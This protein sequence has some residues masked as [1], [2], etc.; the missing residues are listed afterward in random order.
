[1][2]DGNGGPVPIGVPGELYVGGA[3]VARGYLGRPDLTARAVRA[4][5]LRRRPGARGSTAT[6]DLARWRPDGDLEF[7][8]RLDHQVKIRGFRIE[9]GEIEARAAAASRRCRR[10]SWWLGRTSTGDR[11]LVAYVASAAAGE[12]A[13]G[14][15]GSCERLPEPMVPSAFVVPRGAAADAERQGGPPGAARAGP[16]ER[17]PEPDRQGERRAIRYEEM[18]RRHLVRGAG[19]RARSAGTTTSSSWAATRCWPLR[20]RRRLRQAFGSEVPLRTIFEAPTAGGAGGAVEPAVL[21]QGA[22]PPLEPV[23]RD[24][25]L[26]LSFAQE[27]LWFIEQ[28]EPGPP[29]YNMPA[30]LRLQGRLDPAALARSLTELVRRHESLRTRVRAGG[31]PA[32]AGDRSRRRRWCRRWWT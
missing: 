9:L 4:R 25:Q 32:R 7:L 21:R 31:R 13:G 8:G 10:R 15:R 29:V 23:P 19:P 12:R 16:A 22:A 18:R 3:G 5:P 26:P 24:A 11:R 27:R 30:A 28:L 14:L 1:M 17:E 6:G 2:L 20:W